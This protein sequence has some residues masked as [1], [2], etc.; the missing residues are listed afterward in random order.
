MSVCLCV[1][2]SQLQRQNYWTYF[3]QI[4]TKQ[5]FLGHHIGTS[6]YFESLKNNLFFYKKPKTSLTKNFYKKL[7]LQLFWK[8]FY[9]K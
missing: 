1:R 8:N 9:R 6:N 2:I 5:L 3:D 4:Y 7:R